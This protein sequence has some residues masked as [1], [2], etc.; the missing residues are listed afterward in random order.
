MAIERLFLAT[1]ILDRPRRGDEGEEEGGDAQAVVNVRRIAVSCAD[2]V[3]GQMIDAARNG[4]GLRG[5]G[6]NTTLSFPSA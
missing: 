3:A 6:L 1:T 5:P 4:G 2:T